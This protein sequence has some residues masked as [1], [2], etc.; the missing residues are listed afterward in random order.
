MR[1]ILKDAV[2]QVC[3]RPSP[4]N[5]CYWA[6][7]WWQTV[8]QTVLWAVQGVVCFPAPLPEE[9]SSLSWQFLQLPNPSGAETQSLSDTS[10]C[11][12]SEQTWASQSGQRPF[13]HFLEGGH[14]C[15]MWFKSFLWSTG[16][17]YFNTCCADWG[18]LRLLRS[19]A[20][21][22]AASCSQRL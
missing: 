22:P 19:A 3:C 1:E 7:W 5:W 17:V 6:L 12:L 21:L 4:L 8:L 9:S 11:Q 15:E 2:I 14:W 20:L 16:E 18:C 10:L 13:L